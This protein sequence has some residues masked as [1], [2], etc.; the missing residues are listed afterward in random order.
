[1]RVEQKVKRLKF[2]VISCECDQYIHHDV[3]HSKHTCYLIKKLECIHRQWINKDVMN[4]LV[5]IWI[6][7]IF[8]TENGENITE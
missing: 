8:C 2:N 6:A 4:N 3:D 7:L 5:P 1:M